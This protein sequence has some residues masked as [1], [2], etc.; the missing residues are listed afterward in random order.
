VDSQDKSIA[1]PKAPGE[2]TRLL[3]AWRDGRSEARDKL[4]PILYSELKKLARTV[5][6]GRRAQDQPTSL[7]HKAYLR[8]LES[9]VEWDDRRHF[10]AIAAR[11][12]RFVLADEAR[13]QLAGKR[14][15]GETLN[16]SDSLPQVADPLA[17][18][19]EEVLAVHE[20]LEKLAEIR[21]R[22]AKLVE[23]RYFAGMSV[24]E[25]AEVLEIT[26]RTAA[27]DWKTVQ[28]WLHG[29]LRATG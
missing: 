25:T 3:R 16:F 21:P 27:R 23:M 5:G 22:Q 6:Q 4:W 19:P 24:E 1:L 15:S 13:R 20:A 2:V 17:H 28:V 9:D 11:A 18:R 8:L 12:M 26:T 14:G 7:V 10:F 29:E